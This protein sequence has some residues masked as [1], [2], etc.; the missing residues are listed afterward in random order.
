[1]EAIQA[2]IK[3]KTPNDKTIGYIYGIENLRMLRPNDDKNQYESSYLN[4]IENVYIKLNDE[5]Y[6]IVEVLTVVHNMTYQPEKEHGVALTPIAG[7]EHAFN[8]EIVYVVE[9]SKMKMI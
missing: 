4:S 5:D 6:V 2:R 1:M 8:M 3:I 7:E 9:P